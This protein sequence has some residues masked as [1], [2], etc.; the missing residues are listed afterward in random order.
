MKTN[1]AIPHKLGCLVFTADLALMEAVFGI[2][3]S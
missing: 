1:I 3:L 2:L